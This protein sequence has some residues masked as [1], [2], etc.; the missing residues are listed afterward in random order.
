VFRAIR[1]PDVHVEDG[2]DVVAFL[3]GEPVLVAGGGD[4][5]VAAEADRVAASIAVAA[6]PEVG[7]MP[8]LEVGTIPGEEVQRW[9]GHMLAY[10]QTPERPDAVFILR[11]SN[12]SGCEGFCS[13]LVMRS[14]LIATREVYCFFL[15]SEPVK[16]RAASM[17]F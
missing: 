14:I 2:A 8:M 11:F 12:S 13:R 16:W 1:H 3:V 17:S 5:A 10:F 7:M 4:G 9:A 6:M 15:G